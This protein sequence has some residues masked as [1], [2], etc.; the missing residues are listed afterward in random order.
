MYISL[1][2][3]T[4][5]SS[6]VHVQISSTR[7]F[8]CLCDNSSLDCFMYFTPAPGDSGTH[9]TAT[10]YKGTEVRETPSGHDNGLRDTPADRLITSFTCKAL[11]A[12]MFG[13]LYCT[14]NENVTLNFTGTNIGAAQLDVNLSGVCDFKC[15]TLQWTSDVESFNF[16]QGFTNVQDNKM[17]VVFSDIVLY[18]DCTTCDGRGNTKAGGNQGGTGV[19]DHINGV[20]QQNSLAPGSN[21]MGD[22]ITKG[23]NL[24]E[25]SGNGNQVETVDT[26]CK[27]A[28]N[29]KDVQFFIVSLGLSV[30][31]N[32]ILLALCIYLYIIMRRKGKILRLDSISKQN[33]KHK[34]DTTEE[35]TKQFTGRTYQN[36]HVENDSA[37]NRYERD[38]SGYLTPADLASHKDSSTSY[39]IAESSVPNSSSSSTSRDEGEY[40]DVGHINPN[41]KPVYYVGQSKTSLSTNATS[42]G[43]ETSNSSNLRKNSLEMD[44]LP[45]NGRKKSLPGSNLAKRKE[46]ISNLLKFSNDRRP[47]LFTSPIEGSDPKYFPRERGPVR[48][49]LTKGEHREAEH[50]GSSFPEPVSGSS[51]AKAPS[52]K[53]VPR[54]PRRSSNDKNGLPVVPTDYRPKAASAPTP[55]EK[56]ENYTATQENQAFSSAESDENVYN[57]IRDRTSSIYCNL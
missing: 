17:C 18:G 34:Q 19:V 12:K 42:D 47:R 26:G 16:G 44:A 24:T 1:S 53:P 8:Q 6:C 48:Q 49:A 4:S 41:Q 5:Y 37:I 50:D 36:I 31:A 39:G 35:T 40:E 15:I 11:V 20:G 23:S 9:L 54:K 3:I 43:T 14:E 32:F 52:K 21:I 45:S 55:V 13:V 30:G 22:N 33:R 51:K 46:I 38:G 27:N 57:F 10:Y 28:K 29:E 2:I 7:F 56:H 25:S